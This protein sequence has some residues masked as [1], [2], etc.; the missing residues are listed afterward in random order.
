MQPLNLTD[1]AYDEVYGRID[2]TKDPSHPLRDIGQVHCRTLAESFCAYTFDY[3]RGFT[4]VYFPAAFNPAGATYTT[5]AHHLN[6]T[7]V[8]KK[9]NGLVM[10]VGCQ[11]HRSSELVK[12]SDHLA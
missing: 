9:R 8:L 10:F 12:N 11:Q 3:S 5:A 2:Q 1:Y 4:T 7:K 6:G